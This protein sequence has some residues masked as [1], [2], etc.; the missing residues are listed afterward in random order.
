MVSDVESF[1]YRG[2]FVIRLAY[3]PRVRHIIEERKPGRERVITDSR[4]WYRKK[5]NTDII[6]RPVDRGLTVFY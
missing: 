4:P 6:G 5:Q 3:G 1:S 2:P